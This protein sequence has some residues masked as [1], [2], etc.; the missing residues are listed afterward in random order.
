VHPD[1]LNQARVIT[2]IYSWR[3][4][5][6]L[7][8]RA[9]KYKSQLSWSHFSR[10]LS[11]LTK[12]KDTEFRKK[13]EA[14]LI[15]EDLTVEDLL[16]IIRNHRKKAGAPRS[17]RSCHRQIP[18]KGP[19]AACKQIRKYG[20]E[21]ANR[22][23]GWDSSLFNWVTGE[24][25]PEELTDELLEELRETQ[26]DV[27]KL[28]KTCDEVGGKLEKAINR[29]ER[30]SALREERKEEAGGNRRKMDS[31]EEEDVEVAWDG[32]DEDTDIEVEP[33]EDVEVEGEDKTAKSEGESN[34]K[35]LSVKEKLARAKAKAG[36]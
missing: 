10:G 9:E 36:K 32:V 33:E 25:V 15:A 34:G 35:P 16:Q 2:D 27:C 23:D 12:S 30:V 1:E 22:L 17:T 6:K 26:S 18:P 3:D 20:S 21:I 13:C 4:I 14:Q 19:G 28:G 24:A 29:V 5:E 11:L 8:A 7:F 31:H